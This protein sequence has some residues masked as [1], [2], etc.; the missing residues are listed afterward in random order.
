MIT[1]KARLSVRKRSG[2]F[3]PGNFANVLMP[4]RDMVRE[5]T[6]AA[7]AKQA[8]PV[9]FR[10]WPSRQ[11]EYDWPMLQRTGAMRAEVIRAAAA[12]TVRG[13]TLSVR[14]DAPVHFKWHQQGTRL[15]PPR[16]TVGISLR[17]R[18]A[19]ARALAGEAVKIFRS[20]GPA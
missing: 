19:A 3:A 15:L 2:R 18:N 11:H 7:F 17:V 4:L 1:F 14:V 6:E 12:A 8:D 9:N 13:S 10:R 20:R 16:R 5:D